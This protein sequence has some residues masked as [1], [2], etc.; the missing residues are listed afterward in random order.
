[1]SECDGCEVDTDIEGYFTYEKNGREITIE[2]CG[3]CCDK[4]KDFIEHSL[5]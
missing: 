5:P 2:L 1:M 4:V 3:F